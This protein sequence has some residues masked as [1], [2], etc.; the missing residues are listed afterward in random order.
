MIIPWNCKTINSQDMTI[1]LI[2]DRTLVHSG[3]LK[4]QP[5]W[6]VGAKPTSPASRRQQAMEEHNK[7]TS[8]DLLL[9]S[10]AV[11]FIYYWRRM[12]LVYH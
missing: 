4:P 8:M 12:A 6:R 3:E 10:A 9:L 2:I 7:A 1:L 11:K 5:T